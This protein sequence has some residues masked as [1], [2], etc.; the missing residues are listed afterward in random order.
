M[1]S[2]RARHDGVCLRCDW[3]GISS[4]TACPTCGAGLYRVPPRPA[5]GSPA[6]GKTRV[7]TTR[8]DA[9]PDAAEPSAVLLD[10]RS[11]RL[12]A[13]VVVV[14]L[15]LGG[16]WFL[17]DRRGTAP[18]SNAEVLVRGGTLLY[19]VDDGA[20][21]SRLWRWDLADGSVRP[22]PRVRQPVELVDAH[23]AEPGIVGVTSRAPDGDL[24]GSVLRFLTSSNVATPVVRGDLVT[25]GSRGADVVVV[26]RGPLLGPCR[27]HLVIVL[28]TIAPALVEQEYERTMCGDILSVG[29]DAN[30]TYF[31]RRSH[32]RVDVVQAS[33]GRTHHVLAEHALLSISAASD[34]LVVPAAGLPMTSMSLATVRDRGDVP[35]PAVFGTSFSYRRLRGEPRPYR[36][37]NERLW[38]DRV[39]AWSRDS[40]VALVAGR[41]GDRA[42]LYEIVA[43]P[44]LLPEPPRWV[45]PIRGGAWA[46]FSEDGLAFVLTDHRLFVTRDGGLEPLPLPD[47]APPPDGPLVWL[48]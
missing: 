30:S 6:S 47:G 32:D 33:Y 7:S 38:I 25:W 46:T 11:R 16:L 26:K 36:S 12:V 3:S 21:W 2:K 31:T 14:S 4:T 35:P 8:G 19:A 40:A 41:L 24:V 13:A 27:R 34:M 22:G 28:K 43:G 29:R 39:L 37:G 5:P 18:P 44:G 48:G 9:T 23:A 15:S 20:G 1:M 10:G 17:A 45:G 42:G